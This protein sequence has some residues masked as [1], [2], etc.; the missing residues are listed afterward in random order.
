MAWLPSD[1]A[2]IQ[3][4]ADCLLDGEILVLRG[5]PRSGKTSVCEALVD[6]IGDS[7]LMV[8]GRAFTE[9]AQVE[10]Q[11]DLDRDLK[12]R[13]ADFGHAQLLFDDYGSAIRRSRGGAL[14]SALY[15]MLVDGEHARDVGAL[16]TSRLADDLDL[17]FAGS[18]LLSRARSVRAPLLGVDDA[19]AIGMGLEDARRLVGSATVLARRLG[20]DADPV[21]T[22]EVVEYLKAD[23]MPSRCSPGRGASRMRTPSVSMLSLR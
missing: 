9:Q 13:V 19:E 5:L 11:G 20:S 6:L 22:Y 10:R 3:E 4:L 15:R 14:H 2:W 21:K 23:R 16:L 7:A 12:A 18:P 8:R 17:R 1:D